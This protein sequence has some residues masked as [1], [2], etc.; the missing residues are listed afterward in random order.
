MNLRSTFDY[1]KSID[2]SNGRGGVQKGEE[3]KEKA[4]ER[5][6]K[7][8]GEGKREKG[9]GVEETPVCIFKFS[10]E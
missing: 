10:L 9:K 1:R 8:K 4:G 2:Y 5:D 7:R 6:G 3:R